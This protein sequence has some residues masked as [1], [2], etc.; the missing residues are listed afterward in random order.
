M[1]ETCNLYLH[2]NSSMVLP[3]PC[4]ST[5]HMGKCSKMPLG[6]AK[7][8]FFNIKS[9]LGTLL[10]LSLVMLLWKPYYHNI[11]S[12]ASRCSVEV[13]LQPFPV[14]ST[15]AAAA[16]ATTTAEDSIALLDIDPFNRTFREYGSAAALFVHYSAYRGGSNTFAVLGLASK[17]LHVYG[18]PYYKCE[19]V[20]RDGS[21]PIA[22]DT[23]KLLPDWGYGRV[24]TM[25]VVNCTFAEN[26][27][28]DNRGGEL[29]LYA[30]YSESSPKYEKF[31][32]LV[33]PPGAYNESKY[34]PP[35]QYDYLYCGS[36]LYGNISGDRIREWMAYHTWLFGN[37]SHFVFHDAGGVTP[38]VRDALQPHIKAR[39]A[40]V[41]NIRAQAAYD[42][43]Y[44]NQFL[45]VN[46]CLH[47]YRH[48]AKWTFFFDVDEY[49]YVPEPNTLAS[50]LEEFSNSTQFT[51]EQF[52][53][54]A[55]LCL[56]DPSR[57]YSKEWCMEKL[58]FKD[59][60][61]SYIWRDRKYAIQARNAFAAG[62]HMS[63]NVVGGTLHQ[64]ETQIRYY[65]YHNTITVHNELCRTLLPLSAMNATTWLDKI[66]YA[67]DDTMRRVA[68]LVKKFEQDLIGEK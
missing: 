12:A 43:Y 63:E 62:I 31:T 49:V 14:N 4:R 7:C 53:M 47:R 57:N 17:P 68:P 45:V 26:P 19:W 16:A 58:L 60:R 67:Y 66:P 51:I 28:A 35:Y 20:P 61:T 38:E 5:N 48:A 10:A 2:T 46:D 40:V 27:N 15:V 11:L 52:P 8:F 23:Y 50:V 13:E 39:R 9:F 44:Y 34:L 55:A 29:M 64:T 21:T 42:G 32:S 65:H 30:Y 37:N 18:S 36:S 25:V 24:Y 1:A 3:P 22:A 56:D 6:I 54:A 33:E 59:S 41:E